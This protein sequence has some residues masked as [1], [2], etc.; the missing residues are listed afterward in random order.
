MI[1]RANG[2]RIGLVEPL[3]N[4]CDTLGREIAAQLLRAHLR[5]RGS[6]I[7]TPRRCLFCRSWCGGL[8]EGILLGSLR[9]RLSGWHSMISPQKDLPWAGGAAID[10]SALATSPAISSCTLMRSL[11]GR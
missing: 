11:K 2:I 5:F 1:Q 10:F 3:Q 8:R 9:W 6:S 4:L 7:V